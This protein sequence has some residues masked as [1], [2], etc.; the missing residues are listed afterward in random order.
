MIREAPM[1]KNYSAKL[2]L[3]VIVLVSATFIYGGTGQT[4]I[5]VMTSGNLFIAPLAD[6]SPGGKLGPGFGAY[7]EYPF[8]KSFALNVSLDY[9]Q[10]TVDK[11]PEL[12]NNILLASVRGKYFLNPG[13]KVNPFLNAGLGPFSFTQSGG[14]AMPDRY[15]DLIFL[16]GLGAE[17]P[18]SEKVSLSPAINYNISNS[19]DI[20]LLGEGFDT[21]L[22][23]SL[24]VSFKLGK[25]KKHEA[26]RAKIERKPKPSEEVAKVPADTLQELKSKIE[27]KE[28]NLEEYKDIKEEY[29]R[30]INA[31][32][33]M[34]ENKN[35][36]IDSLRK[37]KAQQKTHKRKT[38]LPQEQKVS[39]FYNKSLELFWTK[40]YEQAAENFEALIEN[41]PDHK[42]TSNFIYWAGE[43]YNGMEDY[44]KALKYFEKVEEYPDSPKNDD[45]LIMAG[46]S[47]LRLDR[48]T[49]AKAKFRKLLD[50]YPDS[51]YVEFAEK[52][53][54]F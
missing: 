14:G 5:G 53:L 9:N 42:L 37:A 31:K 29:G 35:A 10:V 39:E 26:P 40:N 22:N 51:E 52:H 30:K 48:K 13:G 11:T 17:I 6:N 27:K 24:G 32:I 54:T 8:S 15:F 7:F 21:Y 18:I 34:I 41:Y 49:E 16:A 28:K 2:L 20:D 19:N 3:A 43:A 25:E 38:V 50:K 46:Q 44:Q 45:A 36:I 4:K 12:Q 33:N 1:K 23:F 47:L